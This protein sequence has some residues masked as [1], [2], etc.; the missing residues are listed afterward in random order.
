MNEPAIESTSDHTA[1]RRVVLLTSPKAGSGANRSQI[2]RLMERLKGASVDAILTND[3]R[4][5]DDLLEKELSGRAQN[6]VV[7]AAG[8]DGTVTLA[9]SRLLAASEKTLAAFKNASEKMHPASHHGIPIVPM[10]LGTENLLARHFGYQVDAD[11]VFR[12]IVSGNRHW[13]DLGNVRSLAKSLTRPKPMRPMLTMVTSGFD[14]EVVRELHLRR[15]GHIRRSSYFRPIKLMSF[16]AI[17]FLSSPLSQLPMT[18]QSIAKS[19]VGGRW[20]LICLVTVV[21]LPLNPMRLE[22][23]VC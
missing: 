5:L 11:H 6:T 1:Q 7:V 19:S 22:T 14:A 3:P 12:T 20:F 23:T 15:S 9:A 10:P 4:D 17:A 8:G 18:E 13:I 16:V 2:P 21:D